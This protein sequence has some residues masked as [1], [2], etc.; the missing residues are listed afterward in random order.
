M[1]V[2]PLVGDFSICLYKD[3]PK[4][5]DLHGTYGPHTFTLVN[6]HRAERR[7]QAKSAR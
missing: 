1:I 3:G 6:E 4:K 5:G 2:F 7:E